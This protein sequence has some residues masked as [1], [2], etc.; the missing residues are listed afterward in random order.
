M[1]R[2]AGIFA[3]TTSVAAVMP[4]VADA[5]L[6]GGGGS[7]CSGGLPWPFTILLVPFC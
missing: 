5:A 1:K 4:A 2:L 3:L 7:E 6:L